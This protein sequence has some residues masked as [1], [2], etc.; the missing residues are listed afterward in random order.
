VKAAVFH[1]RGD[2]RIEAVEDP[3]PEP[4]EL[5]LKIHASGICGTDAHEFAHGPTM[6]PLHEPH[7]VT[8]HVGPTIPGHELA[9]TV[10][11]LSSDVNGFAIDDLVVS[12]AGIWCGE[13]VQCGRGRTNLCLRYATLGLQRDGGLAQYCRVPAATCRA[14]APY[15]LAPDVATL[16]QPMAVATHAMRRGRLTGNDHAVVIGA[17]GIGAFLTFAV[18]AQGAYVTVLDLD[19]ARLD[20]AARLGAHEVVVPQPDVPARQWLPVAPGFPTVVYEV[21]GSPA[22]L[23]TGREL[24]PAGGRLVVVGL[25]A[26]PAELDLRDLTLR[27]IEVIGTNAHVC[28]DDLPHALGLLAAREGSWSDVAP[29]ALGLDD[30]VADG[31]EPLAS[32]HSQRI[33]TLVDPW[34]TA[35]RATEM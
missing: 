19:T 8:G 11:G 30:L 28:D 3:V 14:V 20:L 16:A 22:G 10:V 33:K 24:V 29:V 31:L 32:G 25:Q 21:S 17:G 2:V 26:A 4:G 18:V 6:M 35:R 15:G 12:G 27:E 7:P 1:G 34:I 13:C 23:A 9:G 5:L